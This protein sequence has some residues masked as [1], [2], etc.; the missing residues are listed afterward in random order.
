MSITKVNG[1]IEQQIGANGRIKVISFKKDG[2]YIN[3]QTEIQKE[4]PPEG[5]VFA[6][7][8]FNHFDY[9]LHSLIEFPFNN[10][11][12]NKED[13]DLYLLDFNLECNIIGCPVFFI[14][15]NIL[16]G[17][18]SINQTVLNNY[19]EKFDSIHFYIVF[20]EFLYGPFKR[21]NTKILP[22]SGKEVCRWELSQLP[23]YKSGENTYLL[24]PPLR[25]SNLIDCMT[26]VQLNAWLKDQ[27]RNLKLDIDF[28]SLAEALESQQ[29]VGLDIDRMKRVLSGI[30]Q[31]S[32]THSELKY[33]ASS[34]DRLEILYSDSLVK[35]EKEIKK[36]LIEPIEIAKSEIEIEILNLKKKKEK[37][38]KEETEYKNKVQI[39]KKEFDSVSQEKERLINDI[40][41][42]AMVGMANS[43]EFKRLSTYDE[44]V[45][46]LKE[47][48]YTSITEFIQ[49]LNN[50]LQND[51]DNNKFWFNSIFQLKDYKCILSDSIESILQI[52]K[53][54]NNCK[55]LI[56]QVEPD[57]LKF[58]CL[59]ENG[60]KQIW[61][62]AH[63]NLDMIHFLILEDINMASIECYGK[64]L[65]DIV[66]GIR[67]RLPGVN[68]S[69]PKNLWIFGIPIADKQ[70]HEFGLPLIK[71]TYE[72]WGFFPK[73]QSKIYFKPMGESNKYLS[74]N[75]LFDHNNIVPISSNEYFSD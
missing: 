73:Q 68:S 48:F 15:E 3:N 23:T 29:H 60:L 9:K 57:W 40:K 69:M 47:D 74:V 37:A 14:S 32:L 8:F 51:D 49:V 27:I 38:L 45:Y 66:E 39:L 28:N 62:S 19:S 13:K 36:E 2:V 44:Q 52:A 75:N 31:I 6:P 21:L 63:E 54:S 71:N 7:Y 43:T 46:E 10:F 35:L 34:S 72:K 70:P 41:V 67:L 4:F 1:T 65:I 12:S 61:E 53:L 33:L 5:F 30:D 25:N 64:P 17:E 16:L 20:K 58:E 26:S 11:K 42:H 50:S 22:K 24:T 18:Y 56:Q 59:F 55:V